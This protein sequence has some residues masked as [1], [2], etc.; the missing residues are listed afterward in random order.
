MLVF[1]MILLL[2]LVGIYPFW[3][4]KYTRKLEVTQQERDRIAYFKYVIYSEWTVALLIVA[5][6]A[7]TSTTFTDIGFSLPAENSSQ[8]LGIM[9]GFLVA[10]FGTMFL[11]MKLPFYQRY[12]QKQA[13][14]VSYL[15]PTGK[16]DKRFGIMAAITA[17]IC[18]EIIYRGFLMHFLSSSPFHLEDLIL[19]LTAAAIFGLAHYYQGWKGVLGTALVGFALSRVYVSTGSLLFPILLHI[20]IDLR[21]MLFMKKPS[22][23][24]DANKT[25]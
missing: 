9:T 15:F 14:P 7:V 11:M 2:F 25:M 4:K 12:Q 20:A 6:V 22:A 17:G 18:E 19:G 24:M 13:E 16:L 23:E 21:F 1:G 10:V 5:V 8:S 3:D